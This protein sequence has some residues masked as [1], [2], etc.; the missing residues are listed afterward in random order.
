MS[1][2]ILDQ[3]STHEIT[4]PLLQQNDPIVISNEINKK[5]ISTLKKINEIALKYNMSLDGFKKFNENN[6]LCPTIDSII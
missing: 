5:K 6:T 2:L 1:N 3:L 4:I